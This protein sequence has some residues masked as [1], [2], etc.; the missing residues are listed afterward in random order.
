[1][2]SSAAEASLAGAKAMIAVLCKKQAQ[3]AL[4]QKDVKPENMMEEKNK[5]GNPAMVPIT[6]PT[7]P[8][9]LMAGFNPAL[10]ETAA[11]WRTGNGPDKVS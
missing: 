9:H 6:A 10:V 1:M 7:I 3:L 11:I 2:T 4:F 8:K 5:N